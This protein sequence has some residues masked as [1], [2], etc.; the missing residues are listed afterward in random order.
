LR[1]DFNGALTPTRFGEWFSKNQEG[2]RER[3]E[4]IEDPFSYSGIEWRRTSEKWNVSF[5]LDFASESEKMTA[6]GADVVVLKPAVENIELLLKE[7][8]TKPKKIIFTHYMDFPVGQMNALAVAQLA[9][10]K[11]GDQIGVCGLQNQDLFAQVG[12]QNEIRNEGPFIIPPSGYGLGFE[13]EFERLKW[14]EF[15]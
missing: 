1:L 4:F 11:L 2:L 5:A 7:L 3:L 12:F 6:D 10:A 14:I 8:K 15:E 13:K 9:A